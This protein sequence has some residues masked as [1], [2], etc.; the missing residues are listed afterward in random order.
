MGIS[1]PRNAS[2]ASAHTHELSLQHKAISRDRLMRETH[3][4]GKLAEFVS[5]H[6]EPIFVDRYQTASL[7]SF[8]IQSKVH[9]MASA[10]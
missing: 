8:T 1:I 3:G 9:T 4:Y 6:E 2:D 10:F 7:L 5:T